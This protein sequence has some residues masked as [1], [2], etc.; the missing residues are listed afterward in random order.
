[1]VECPTTNWETAMSELL[2]LPRMARRLGVTQQWL[3]DQADAGRV[4]NLKAGRRYLFNA[5]AVEQALA[6][7]AASLPTEKGVVQ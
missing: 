5:G 7:E 3:R 1:M 6:V 2:S 4:P